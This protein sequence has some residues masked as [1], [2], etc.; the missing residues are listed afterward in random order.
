MA[1]LATATEAQMIA[2]Y[3]EMATTAPHENADELRARRLNIKRAAALV[4]LGDRWIGHPAYVYTP[5]HSNDPRVWPL[6][7]ILRPIGEAARMA[8]RI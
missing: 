2:V 1:A 6:H 3:R 8:G 4:Y 5:R 7:S